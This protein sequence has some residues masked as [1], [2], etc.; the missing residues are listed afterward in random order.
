MLAAGC[1]SRAAAILICSI[2]HPVSPSSRWPPHT[3]LSLCHLTKYALYAV[4]LAAL[5]A[6]Q[7]DDGAACSATIAQL[8]AAVADREQQ[9][10]DL[11][12]QVETWKVRE[13]GV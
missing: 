10:A 11:Q 12:K 9:V 4:C 2:N 13:I 3:P 7:D 6:A 1:E 8:Q 5:Q